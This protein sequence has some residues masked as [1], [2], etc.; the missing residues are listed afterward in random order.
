MA[1][2]LY[3]SIYPTVDIVA[4]DEDLDEVDSSLQGLLRG[5]H[6][7]APWYNHSAHFHNVFDHFLNPI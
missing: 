3:N 6:T 5:Y 1:D 2:R 7:H 4:A